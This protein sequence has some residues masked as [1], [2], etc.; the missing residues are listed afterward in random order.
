MKKLTAAQKEARA[1]I[2]DALARL[3]IDRNKLAELIGYPSLHRARYGEIPLPEAKR[4]AIEL[5]L[6]AHKLRWENQR[7]RTMLKTARA[8]I[9]ETRDALQNTVNLLDSFLNVIA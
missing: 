6:E 4:R 5:V 2:D 3:K 7:L 8:G 9:A 1:F